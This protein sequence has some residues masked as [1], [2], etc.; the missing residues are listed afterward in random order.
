MLCNLVLSGMVEGMKSLSWAPG[1]EFEVVT[2]SIDPSEGSDLAAAKKKNHVDA[3]GKPE[4]AKGW[5]FLT[6]KESDITRVADAIGFKYRYIPATNDFS[7]TAAIFTISPEG[8]IS[9]YLYG[10]GYPAKDLHLALLDA[11]EGKS[12]SIGEKLLMFCYYYDPNAKGYVLFAQRF[13]TG[14]GAM[15]L[16]TL[17]LLLLGLWRKEIRKKRPLENVGDVFALTGRVKGADGKE[18]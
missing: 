5:H 12:L 18:E 16:G 17:S 7:H 3:L 10:V 6:G 11:A 8:K 9:R 4:A 13:M 1:K 14:G 15:V 2:V